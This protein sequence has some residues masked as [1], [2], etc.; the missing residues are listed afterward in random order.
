MQSK[1]GG[2]KC[3][4]SLEQ[5]P[6]ADDPRTMLAGFVTQLKVTATISLAWPKADGNEQIFK[7]RFGGSS[8]QNL[9]LQTNM[10]SLLFYRLT[11]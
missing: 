1:I 6:M 4:A 3:P 7:L 2:E 5:F 10:Q 8:A 11:T 9:H